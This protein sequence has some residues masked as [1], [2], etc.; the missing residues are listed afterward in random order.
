MDPQVVMVVHP[1]ALVMDG[2][3]FLLVHYLVR[4]LQDHKLKWRTYNDCTR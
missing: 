3:V 2:V 1:V 4:V